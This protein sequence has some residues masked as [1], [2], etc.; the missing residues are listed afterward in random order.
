[1]PRL[2]IKTN[3]N[4]KS[5][6]NALRASVACIWI[7]NKSD[8]PP[9]VFLEMLEDFRIMDDFIMAKVWGSFKIDFNGNRIK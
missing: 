3:I 9:I 2:L 1:L 4:L 7:L 8:M 5:S 6:F